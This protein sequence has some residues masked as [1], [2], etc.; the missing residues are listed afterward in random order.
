MPRKT[1]IV[2][3]VCLMTFTPV[4]FAQ[5]HRVDPRNM[6]ERV[7]VVL[8][9]VGKG[10]YADPRRPLYAPASAAINPISRT[11]ILGFTYVLSDDGQSALAEFVA[12]DRSAFKDILNDKTL[13]PFL[14][15]RDK[16][17]DALTEFKK[18]KK[19]FDFKHFGVAIP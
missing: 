11:A 9:I 19:D 10:T 7:L 18:H 3:F 2:A 6:Y 8:P 15:N 1:R 4:A 16:V 5:P 12:K 13:K 14:K 17:E